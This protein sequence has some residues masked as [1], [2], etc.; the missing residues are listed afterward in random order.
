L[1]IDFE[2]VPAKSQKNLQVFLSEMSDAFA[3]HGLAIVL[4]MPFDDDSWPYAAYAKIADYIVLMGYDEHWHESRSGSI[5]GQ[6]WFEDTLD[7]RM[8]ELD[9]DHTI[10]AIGG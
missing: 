1:T 5:A 4:A 9:P 10:V 2:E 8:K 7:K 3:E 6:S